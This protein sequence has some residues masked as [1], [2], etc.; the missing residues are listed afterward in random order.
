[1]DTDLPT[2]GSYREYVERFNDCDKANPE[3]ISKAMRE[4]AQHLERGCT[5]DIAIIAYGSIDA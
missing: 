5:D 3:V 4:C 1:M 2:D